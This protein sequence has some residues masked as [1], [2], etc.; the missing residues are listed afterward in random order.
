MRD[1]ESANLFTKKGE[2]WEVAVGDWQSIQDSFFFLVCGWTSAWRGLMAG[3]FGILESS[4]TQ[5]YQGVSPTQELYFHRH[6]YSVCPKRACEL[7]FHE[8]WLKE[9]STWVKSQWEIGMMCDKT[10]TSI[11]EDSCHVCLWIHKETEIDSYQ[12]LCS[13]LT[14]FSSNVPCLPKPLKSC[15]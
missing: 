2:F 10:G 3:I 6:I 11:V 8:K 15:K 13:P 9:V 14:K 4:A 12:S 1:S 5:W 7:S